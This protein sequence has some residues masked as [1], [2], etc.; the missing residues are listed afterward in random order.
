MASSSLEAAADSAVRALFPLT[1]V[2]GATGTIADADALIE[3]CTQNTNFL[4]AT[5]RT[6]QINGAAHPGSHWLQVVRELRARKGHFFNVIMQHALT[7]PALNAATDKC[8]D[9]LLHESIHRVATSIELQRRLDAE[10]RDLAITE[11]SRRTTAAAVGAVLARYPR[12]DR[13]DHRRSAAEKRR[14]RLVSARRAEAATATECD[15]HEEALRE[16]D[17]GDRAS[18]EAELRRERQLRKEAE[19]R[20]K[21][22]DKRVK[23]DVKTAITKTKAAERSNGKAAARKRKAGHARE[24][25][26]A[27]GKERERER[28]RKQPTGEPLHTGELKHRRLVGEG[29][30]GGGGSGGGGSSHGGKEGGK[31]GDRGGG[32]GSKRSGSARGGRSRG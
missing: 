10:R 20:A 29:G 16:A 11:A 21:Q 1:M 24:V 15:R 12:R 32:R 22:A 6:P 28:K 30:G 25:K 2:A 26:Q 4:V 13:P 14:R 31:G 3:H 8:A 7:E 19:A 23:R 18:L 5:M 9:E 27:L 17:G